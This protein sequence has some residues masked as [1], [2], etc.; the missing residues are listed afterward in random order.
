MKI[1]T[2]C[3]KEYPDDAVV[4]SVDNEPLVD[5]TNPATGGAEGRGKVNGVW[6]GVYGYDNKKV[7]DGK[8]VSFT[9]K[10]KQ[11]WL[12]SHFTGAVIEDTPLGMPGTGTIDGYFDSPRIEFTKQMPVGYVA[13]PDGGKITLREHVLAEGQP[14]RQDLPSAP[15]FYEGTFL[16][17]DRVQGTWIIRP[18]RFPLPGGGYLTVSQT[19]GIWCAQF[20]TGDMHASPTGGPKEA[21]FD[22]SL[23]PE[24]D[25]PS[26]TDSVDGPGLVSMGKFSVGDAEELLKRFEEA[27]LRFE[28]NRDDSA[29]RQMAPIAV[30]TGGLSGTAPMIEIF[31][32]P[33]DEAKAV[34]IMGED[35]QV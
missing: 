17:A 29:I 22:K 4:C 26:E 34:E 12:S 33:E 9:L 32:H 18:G 20:I 15:I 13:Q 8:I 27:K 23:L 6:R 19:T 11:D 28:I 3:G 7:F 2:Y 5:P 21:F 16:D 31:I 10:L 24:P 14:C 35:T 25:A 1:C 30:V